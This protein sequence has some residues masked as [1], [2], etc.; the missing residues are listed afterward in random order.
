MDAMKK[1][2]AARIKAIL[3]TQVDSYRPKYGR[4][5]Q[6]FKRQ[7]VIVGTTNRDDYLY[8]ETGE[9]RK[10]PVEIG[11]RIDI[12]W[13][14]LNREQ[15]F[16]EAMHRYKQGETWWDYPEVAANAIRDR[17]MSREFNE[18]RFDSWSEIISDYLSQNSK[19][20]TTVN[21]VL[22]NALHFEPNRISRNDQMRA[23]K[24]LK[25]IGFQPM[26][27]KKNGVNVRFWCRAE[28]WT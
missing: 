8:D 20:E 15:L 12:N 27:A 9:R 14:N 6:N 11:E 18:D 10:F 5:V 19:L 28:A 4:N 16:A 3:S 17:K 25:T 2:D 1:A 13:I 22:L 21:D 23:S 24:C 7:C 26:R